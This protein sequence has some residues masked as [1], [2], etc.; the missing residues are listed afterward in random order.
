MRYLVVP[1][2]SDEP[3]HRI[4]PFRAAEEVKARRA[5]FATVIFDGSPRPAIRLRPP[6]DYEQDQRN[7]PSAAEDWRVMPSIVPRG[8]AY[9]V[10]Q[11]QTHP[12]NTQAD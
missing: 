12:I 10:V 2:N 9:Y 7:Q 6:Q 1:Y 8:G 11:L 3:I 5:K 4:S